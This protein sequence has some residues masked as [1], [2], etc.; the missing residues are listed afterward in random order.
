M[1][2]VNIPLPIKHVVEGKNN[3][4][5][6]TAICLTFIL[7]A[8]IPEFDPNSI[9]TFVDNLDDDWDKDGFT[10]SNGDCDDT[11]SEIYPGAIEYCNGFDNDC[12]G[13]LDDDPPRYQ[14]VSR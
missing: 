12:N 1:N 7:S 9:I 6:L 3:M 2:Y 5:P 11:N 14:M 10:E 13:E 8:C 4:K